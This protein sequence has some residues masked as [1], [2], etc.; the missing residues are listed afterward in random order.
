MTQHSGVYRDRRRTFEKQGM[1]LGDALEIVPRLARG[2]I[3]LTVTSPPYYVGKAYDSS[4]DLNEFRKL[5]EKLLPAVVEATKDGGSICW[6]V[7]YHIKNGVATPLDYVV[8]SI[9]SDFANVYLR[10]RIVW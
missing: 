2:A 10:N 1:V 8:H 9:M 5:H 6:Q 4:T 7:G 3:A